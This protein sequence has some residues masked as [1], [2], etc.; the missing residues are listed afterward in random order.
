MQLARRSGLHR[1]EAGLARGRDARS[2]RDRRPAASARKSSAAFGAC[3]VTGPFA[4]I[5]GEKAFLAGAAVFVQSASGSSSDTC[6]E[7]K[8]IEP[9]RNANGSVPNRPSEPSLGVALTK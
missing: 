4:F 7:A 8:K 1:A 2:V 3:S 5:C 9:Q 6:G